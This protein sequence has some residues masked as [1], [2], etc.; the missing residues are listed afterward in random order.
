MRGIIACGRT[1]RIGWI[2]TTIS[3]HQ[4]HRRRSTSVDRMTSI[5]LALR[6]TVM[7]RCCPDWIE[8]RVHHNRGFAGV[9]THP[10]LSAAFAQIYEHM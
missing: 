9:G 10:K 4:R 6:L 8:R 7:P 3:K 1:D 5:H 2:S